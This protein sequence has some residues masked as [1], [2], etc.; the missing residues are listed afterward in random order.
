MQAMV[1]NEDTYCG[2]EVDASFVLFSKANVWRLL[3][4]SV[5]DNDKAGRID[6]L[7]TKTECSLQ[8]RR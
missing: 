8:A 2:G 5:L 1:E 3:V 6:K 7:T 4:Q